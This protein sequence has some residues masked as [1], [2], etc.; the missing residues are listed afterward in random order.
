MNKTA[1]ALVG[2]IAVVAVA[3]TGLLLSRGRGGVAGGR[4]GRG[5]EAGSAAAASAR[6]PSSAAASPS[7]ASAEET[8]TRLSLARDPAA[9]LELIS[10]YVAWAR[11]PARTNDRRLL[12]EKVAANEEPMTAVNLLAAAATG[13]PTPLE[14]DPL[15]ADMARALSPVW[16]DDKTFATGRDLMRLAEHDKARALLA[17][18][19]TLRAD[20]PPGGLSPLSGG[21]RHE[22]ASDLIQINMH[23]SNRTLKA[24]TLT[25]VRTIAGPAVAEILADPANAATSLAARTAEEANVAARRAI[26]GGGN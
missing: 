23:T 4:D 12:I 19:L 13:D 14:T 17:A 3:A 6:A 10:L 26:R 24:Q 15:I 1:A 2:G 8:I 11:D 22:L 16:R 25:H 9:R 5:A 18:T 21:E 20:R 7:S